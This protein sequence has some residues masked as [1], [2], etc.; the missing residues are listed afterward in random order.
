MTA[1][2]MRISDWSSYVC[3]FDL[4]CIESPFVRRECRTTAAVRA[5]RRRVRPAGGSMLRVVVVDDEA[6]ARRY[7]RRLIESLDGPQ[8]VAAADCLQTAIEA[9]NLPR[10]D[11]VLLDTTLTGSRTDDRR[12]G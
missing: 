5:N 6:P 11:P 4:A 10:P 2:N 3:S 1:Y 9:V 12:L 7:L 8:V